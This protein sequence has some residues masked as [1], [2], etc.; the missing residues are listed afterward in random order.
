[1]TALIPRTLDIERLGDVDTCI[2]RA[3]LEEG[4]S[5][6]ARHLVYLG[7]IWRELVSRG[8]D[9]SD[10]RTGI[11][12]YI[13]LVAAGS[14]APETVVMIAGN[15]RLLDKIASLPADEQRAVLARKTLPLAVFQGG[16]WTSQNVQL[17]AV[18]ASQI[19]VIFGKRCVRS[20]SEQVTIL[21]QPVLP[22]K[23]KRRV[24]RGNIIIDREAGTIRIVG[25]IAT[26]SDLAAAC[27]KA[28]VQ[29]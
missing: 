11:A 29:V 1:M 12:A 19:A 25:G 8:E 7:A 13:P 27:A 28:G 3:E 26:L 24:R 10:L 5:I 16:E 22:F 6:T 14:V 23:P 15:P 4:L 17:S 18:T 9:L 20:L 21:T 2:L